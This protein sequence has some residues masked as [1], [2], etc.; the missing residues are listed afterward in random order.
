VLRFMDWNDTNAASTMQAHASTRRQR[1][2]EQ[3]QPVAIEWQIDL[4]NRL[5]ADCW[6][7]LHHT[8]SPADWQ[9]VAQLVRDTL[10]PSLRVYVEWSNEVWNGA[11]PQHDYAARM[12]GQLDLPGKDRAAA[13][14]VYSSVRLFDSF[15]Q[16]FAQQPHRLVRV[17]AGQAAWTGPC[18]AH[19]AALRDPKINPTAARPDAYAIAPYLH[20]ESVAQLRGA[21]AT[22][23][24]WTSQHVG[25]AQ[26]LGVPLIS[27]EGGT[28]SYALGDGCIRLQH[29]PD[30]RALYRDYLQAM[31]AAGMRGPFMQYTHSG[32]CWGLK[33]KT[34]DSPE[35][36]PR[37]QGMTDWLDTQ[38]GG[39]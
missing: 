23:R 20:G 1:T 27:Y 30:M 14:Y 33:E 10:K 38:A 25:C 16:V 22:A 28:D 26:T 2:G 13:A 31:A 35:N 11:F 21:I 39:S 19:V 17:L 7:N 12:A 24:N 32:A 5:D 9:Q 8:S 37:Y 36:S 6:I 34:G 18:E 4:C 15:G 3:D 29:H